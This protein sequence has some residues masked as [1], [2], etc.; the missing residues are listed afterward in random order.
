ME[1]LA[2]SSA[3]SSYDY[4]EISVIPATEFQTVVAA[5]QRLAQQPGRDG[6][7]VKHAAHALLVEL[8][9]RQYAADAPNAFANIRGQ[10][11]LKI[12]LGCGPDIRPGWL[13]IDLVPENRGAGT[14]GYAPFINHDLR[15]G[16]PVEEGCAAIIYSSHFFE[17]L[18]YDLGLN[19]MR[20]C[21]RALQPGG[22][23]RIALPDLPAI[24]DA[25]LRRDADWLSLL[26]PF[27][28][29]RD[30]RT[31]VD[32]VNYGVYQHGEHKCVYDI[33]KLQAMLTGIGFSS[34]VRADYDP[35][36]DPSTELRRRYSFYAD[37]VKS[38]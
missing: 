29:V 14:I 36:L 22:R 3:L 20:E 16:L 2:V 5:L 21:H 24:F 10:R 35:G 32:Y 12:H 13:N 8:N 9:L 11:N 18:P 31:I 33:E 27:V 19:L 26:D 17:H 38:A 23:F 25:Y 37:A 4:E 7:G 15:E 28:G 34:V 1:G 30:F 6:L